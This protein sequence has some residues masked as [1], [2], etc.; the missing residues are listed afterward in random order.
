M[1][2]ANL[3]EGGI[4]LRIKLSKL[5]SHLAPKEYARLGEITRLIPDIL[6]RRECNN[7]CFHLALF[8]LQKINVKNLL[9]QQIASNNKQAITRGST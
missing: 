2:S 7:K 8:L 1:Q 6:N 3:C 9:V 4:D 5:H